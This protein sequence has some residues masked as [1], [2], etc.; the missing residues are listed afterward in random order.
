MDAIQTMTEIDP[1]EIQAELQRV[2]NA[3]ESRP[4]QEVL[5]WG[6][7]VLPTAPTHGP[8][9]PPLTPGELRQFP[10][11]PSKLPKLF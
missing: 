3:F 1:T 11:V 2:S 7:E 5:R 4:P 8:S 9:S 10:D 6:V